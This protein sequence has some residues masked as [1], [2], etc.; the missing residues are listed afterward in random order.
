MPPSLILSVLGVGIIL[1][2]LGYTYHKGSQ[3]CVSFYEYQIAQTALKNK[4]IEV[5]N[6]K[7]QSEFNETLLGEANLRE[8]ELENAN[9]QLQEHIN[10]INSGGTICVDTEF[11]QQL[12]KLR[13]SSSKKAN[14]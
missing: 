10:T 8:Q 13:G 4:E 12:R 5:K 11:L 1:G 2:I 7:E 6:Y 3:S 14:P 9:K